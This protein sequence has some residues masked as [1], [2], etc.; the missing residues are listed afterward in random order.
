MEK[1]TKKSVEDLEKGLEQVAE[2]IEQLKELSEAEKGVPRGLDDRLQNISVMGQKLVVDIEETVERA[3]QSML[4]VGRAFFNTGV[5]ELTSA[6]ITIDEFIGDLT[7]SQARIPTPEVRDSSP[8]ASALRRNKQEFGRFLE[9]V[10]QST[11]LMLESAET[12]LRQLL[13]GN[14]EIEIGFRE[15]KASQAEGFKK[16]EEGFRNLFGSI[17]LITDA[18]SLFRVDLEQIFKKLSL[19]PG[20]LQTE[21]GSREALGLPERMAAPFWQSTERTEQCWRSVQGNLGLLSAS[22]TSFGSTIEATFEQASRAVVGEGQM[23]VDCVNTDLKD[24]KEEAKD[25]LS[26]SA[27]RAVAQIL[28]GAD[29]VE[30]ALDNLTEA[31]E[32]KH[33]TIKRG[34]T[35][36]LPSHFNVRL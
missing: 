7:K 9:L 23:A 25:A 31:G 32:K 26:P 35:S 18:T 12:G 17:N 11:N 5:S 21:L 27:A 33:D 16:I 29:Q 28:E 34:S 36:K 6:R 24:I 30:N 15:V 20:Q 10:S 1:K 14:E 2:G 22:L 3:V 19:L 4:E 13:E 8:R